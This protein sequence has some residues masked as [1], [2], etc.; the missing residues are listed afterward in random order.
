M[1]VKTQLT[2]S[3]LTPFGLY[4]DFLRI[5]HPQNTFHHCADVFGRRRTVLAV[6]HYLL[7]RRVLT[8]WCWHGSASHVSGHLGKCLLVSFL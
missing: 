3:S 2:A 1:P 4:F 5:F 7:E 8:R 6:G